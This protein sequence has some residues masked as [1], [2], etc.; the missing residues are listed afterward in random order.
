MNRKEDKRT[1]FNRLFKRRIIL[2]A[3]ENT[4]WYLDGVYFK[5][6]M[7]GFIFNYIIDEGWI[8]SNMKDNDILRLLQSTNKKCFSIHKKA[9][10]EIS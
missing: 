9:K 10:G 3:P 5:K 7:K 4:D 6:G 8:K 1:T 2:N